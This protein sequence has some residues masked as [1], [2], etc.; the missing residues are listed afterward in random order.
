MQ[1]YP[2]YIIARTKKKMN[3]YIKFAMA[4]GSMSDDERILLTRIRT[5]SMLQAKEILERMQ[6]GATSDD[7]KKRLEEM[8]D[9]L[10]ESL[11]VQALVDG[12]ITHE[13]KRIIEEYKRSNP[14]TDT[15]DLLEKLHHV[16]H[17]PDVKYAEE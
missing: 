3:S 13:E 11:T 1:L 12:E 2:A 10:I 8:S 5:E 9:S 7:L 4:D 17:V 15:L 14:L 6:A 16:D